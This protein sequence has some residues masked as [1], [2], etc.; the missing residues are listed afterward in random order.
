M[1]TAAAASKAIVEAELGQVDPL[2]VVEHHRAAHAG[3]GE[4]HGAEV[5]VVTKPQ[6]AVLIELI[7]DLERVYEEEPAA[8]LQHACELAKDGAAHFGRQLM[9][10]GDAGHGAPGFIVQRQSFPLLQQ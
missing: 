10:R 1:V 9:E 4:L 7:S 5:D 6:H 8:M 3:L 2:H